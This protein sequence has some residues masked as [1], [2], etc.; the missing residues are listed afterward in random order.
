MSNE[1]YWESDN[2]KNV[3]HCF[4]CTGDGMAIPQIMKIVITTITHTRNHTHTHTALTYLMET[5]VT[6]TALETTEKI[7][8][9]QRTKNAFSQASL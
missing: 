7:V 2:L 4:M 3:G 5:L 9:Y 6:T 8:K 1:N